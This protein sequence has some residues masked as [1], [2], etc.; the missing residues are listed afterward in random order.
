MSFLF[1]REEQF[2]DLYKEFEPSLINSTVYIMSMAM[3]MATFAINYKVLILNTISIFCLCILCSVTDSQH[4]LLC[5][6][7]SPLH[8]VSQREST[9]TMEYRPVRFSDCRTSYWFITRIQ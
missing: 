4:C 7:G 3:Q 5:P 1:C 9:T 6:I 2:V 8:G